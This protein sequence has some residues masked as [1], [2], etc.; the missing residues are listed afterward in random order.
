MDIAADLMVG[1][2]LETITA[3]A[4]RIAIAL[5][6]AYHE[7]FQEAAQVSTRTIA[8]AIALVTAPAEIRH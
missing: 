2:D 5:V 3:G 8:E 4:E 7:G 1:E 6:C